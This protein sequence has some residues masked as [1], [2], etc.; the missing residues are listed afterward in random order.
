[1]KVAG[2]LLIQHMSDNP[3][4]VLTGWSLVE[5]KLAPME[6]ALLLNLSKELHPLLL[7]PDVSALVVEPKQALKRDR[8][9]LFALLEH[10]MSQLKPSFI[11]YEGDMINMEKVLEASGLERDSL[12]FVE[13]TESIVANFKHKQNVN[14]AIM[15]CMTVCLDAGTGRSDPHTRFQGIPLLPVAFPPFPHGVGFCLVGSL[16]SERCRAGAAHPYAHRCICAHSCQYILP[17]V[18]LDT[19][20]CL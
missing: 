6:W 19:S 18:L 2:K 20:V 15:L 1:M 13:L 10:A 4:V 17:T 11:N 8:A 16:L 5:S 3:A 12:G 9:P 14:L 7:Q